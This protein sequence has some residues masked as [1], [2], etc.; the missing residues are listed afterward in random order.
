MALLGVVRAEIL[1]TRFF[2]QTVNIKKMN[3]PPHLLIC[4]D[5][6]SE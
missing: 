2:S 3:C 6:E 1:F 4:D 5:F